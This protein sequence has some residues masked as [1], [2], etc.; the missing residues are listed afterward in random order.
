MNFTKKLNFDYFEVKKESDRLDGIVNKISYLSKTVAI[1]IYYELKFPNIG[2]VTKLVR[3]DQG[4]YRPDFIIEFIIG[5]NVKYFILDSKYSMLHTLMN[6]HL[7]DCIY[8]Y[9]LNTG[10]NGEEYMKPNSIVLLFP[11]IQ[12]FS[13][14]DNPSFSPKI[15]CIVSKPKFESN[16]RSFIHSIIECELPNLLYYNNSSK[17]VI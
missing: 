7:P 16:L 11:G 15:K 8:K 14:V 10:I 13:Y 1:N 17:A 5:S 2:G 4:Y 3:L 6:K 9:L 12:D